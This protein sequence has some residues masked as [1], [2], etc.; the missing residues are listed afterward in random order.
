LPELLSYLLALAV[1]AFA[2]RHALDHSKPTLGWVERRRKRYIQA[3][4][5][6]EAA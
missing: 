4:A 2:V 3:R 5:L 1:L 6:Y